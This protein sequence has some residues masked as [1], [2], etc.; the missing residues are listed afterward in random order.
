MRVEVKSL[1]R[2]MAQRVQL[3]CTDC[4][5]CGTSVPEGERCAS[6]A[7]RRVTKQRSEVEVEV[8][9]GARHKTKV[10]LA[11]KGDEV[12]G[13][14]GRTG[15][16]IVTIHQCEHDRFVRKGDDLVL[17][18]KL[19]LRES[20]C[21]CAVEIE[22]L[23]GRRLLWKS[24]PGQV[25][26]HGLVQCIEGEGFPQTTPKQPRGQQPSSPP[27]RQG[28]GRLLIRFEVELPSLSVLLDPTN[29]I[30]AALDAALPPPPPPDDGHTVPFG[31]DASDTLAGKASSGSEPPATP[32][33]PPPQVCVL[34]VVSLEAEEDKANSTDN[35]G[36]GP[37]AGTGG[38][39]EGQQ[40]CAQ[41]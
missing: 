28:K 41:Q 38:E 25:I 15:D 21:G 11:G 32:P 31:A 27:A 6:C 9:P 30:Q 10:V 18:S 3:R 14:G 19:S 2:G 37:G 34:E 35:T 4:G 24:A 7:G 26:E 13:E 39:E 36:G 12:A 8:E 33:P 16:V 5:G 22:H 23:D 40:Q 17:Q 20:L 29:G 1:G